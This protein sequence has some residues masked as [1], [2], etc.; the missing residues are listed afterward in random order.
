MR[1]KREH[2]VNGRIAGPNEKRAARLLREMAS[3]GS[4][5]VQWNMTL[6]EQHQIT[7]K[8]RSIY[9]I[10]CLCGLTPT[11]GGTSPEQQPLQPGPGPPPG[12]FFA[13][14]NSHT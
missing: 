14:P 11:Q 5:E 1:T 8:L 4:R 2:R 7:T 9:H 6:S 13:N 3:R 12:L 10:F